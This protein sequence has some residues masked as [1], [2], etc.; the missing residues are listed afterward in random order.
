MRKSTQI[1]TG[2]SSCPKTITKF[3]STSRSG[4]ALRERN[5]ALR[6]KETSW[7]NV[8]LLSSAVLLFMIR[9]DSSFMVLFAQSGIKRFLA[10]VELVSLCQC[11]HITI[12]DRFYRRLGHDF[13]ARLLPS[14]LEPGTRNHRMALM[15]LRSSSG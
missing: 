3:T 12:F 5:W 2:K 13:M 9:R 15:P 10:M 8:N 14:Q 6:E 4:W 11:E 1:H 7:H